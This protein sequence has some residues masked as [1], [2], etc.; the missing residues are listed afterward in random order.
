[1]RERQAVVANRKKRNLLEAKR[2]IKFSVEKTAKRKI[3]KK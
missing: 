2:V 1:M 3:H